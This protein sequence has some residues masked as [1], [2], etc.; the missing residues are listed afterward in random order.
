MAVQVMMVATA[1]VIHRRRTAITAATT[2]I[3]VTLNQL[4]SG[5]DENAMSSIPQMLAM[6]AVRRL[7][8]LARNEDMPIAKRMKTAPEKNALPL[9]KWLTRGVMMR[10]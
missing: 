3:Q 7:I 2:I 10:V 8:R 4:G 9:T 5:V 1:M 6:K